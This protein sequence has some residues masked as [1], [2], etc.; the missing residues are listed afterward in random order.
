[1]PI[2]A[3]TMVVARAHLGHSRLETTG[4]YLYPTAERM[5]EAVDGV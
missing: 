3:V 5:Q 2:S 4:R 1:M